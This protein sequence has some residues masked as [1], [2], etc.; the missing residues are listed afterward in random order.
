MMP[1]A[2]N[3]RDLDTHGEQAHHGL[4]MVP[5]RTVPGAPAPDAGPGMD[6]RRVINGLTYH[7]FLFAVFGSLLGA[8]LGAAAWTLLPAKYTTYAV[9]HMASR[10]PGNQF[11]RSDD[12]RSEFITF[13][14]SQASVIKNE[15]VLRPALNHSKIG[16]TETLRRYDDPVRWLEENI[17]V[18]FSENSEYVKISL[19]GD[20]P[21]ELADIVNAVTDAYIREVVQKDKA[22]ASS[23]I[24]ALD[25]IR[26]SF[27]GI[28]KN[29]QILV[30]KEHADKGKPAD[31]PPP[32]TDPAR[33]P[34]GSPPVA[35][36][37]APK[38]S[39]GTNEYAR[40]TDNL[41]RANVEHTVAVEKLKQIDARIAKVDT[42]E[43]AALDLENALKTD[44]TYKGLKAQAEKAKKREQYLKQIT[45]DLDNN[46]DYQAAVKNVAKTK[47]DA[48][49]HV[50]KVKAEMTKAFQAAYRTQLTGQ[51]EQAAFFVEKAKLEV[52]SLRAQIAAAVVVK[53]LVPSKSVQDLNISPNDTTF[54]QM[55]GVFALLL[56]RINILKIAIQTPPRVNVIQK[57]SVPIKKEMKKQVLGA[58]FGGILGFAIVGGL[59]TL[60]EG[61][62]R[63]VFNSKEIAANPAINLIG[64]LPEI[65]SAGIKNTGAA[66]PFMEAVDQVRVMFSRNFLG[67]RAQTILITSAEAGE[68]KTTLAGHLAVSMTKTDRKTV[69]VDCNLR[70]PAMHHHLGLPLGPGVC[71]LLRGDKGV[72]DVVQRTAI[73]NLWFMSAGTY[74]PQ[75]QQAIG[76][77][78]FRRVIEKLRQEFDTIIIDSHAVLPVADTLL[79][80]QHCDAVVLC[81]RRFV[82]RKPLVDEAYQ[83]ISELGVA[84]SGLIFMGESPR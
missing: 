73:N 18:E 20:N 25:E 42:I 49:D 63:R 59:I 30:Q 69:L 50:R 13:L 51:R 34:G 68:G 60:F 26:K 29:T 84:H 27:E 56:K 71:E 67:K 31:A 7:W 12:G 37:D 8:G 45:I 61:R 72:H 6:P 23:R 66:D 79:V 38:I 2:D 55:S 83:R 3:R 15:V 44:E 80:G 24:E 10:D 47:A 28:L 75:A 11:E 22:V 9:L 32:P 54:D 16:N 36:P 82:S 5:A 46:A 48:E 78:K 57:A 4:R 58:G 74:D 76:R 81:A 64:L 77:D 33:T 21:Q 43:V 70:G 17:Q 1:I 65:T 62:V 19:T 41:R 52:E 14:K 35:T 40:M 39:V 53:D